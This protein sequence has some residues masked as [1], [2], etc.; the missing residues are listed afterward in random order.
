[1]V[2]DHVVRVARYIDIWKVLFSDFQPLEDSLPQ[3][4]LS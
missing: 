3:G 2:D 1:M 4:Y